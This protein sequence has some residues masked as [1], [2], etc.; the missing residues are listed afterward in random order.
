[1]ADEVGCNI[2]MKGDGHVGGRKVVCEHGCVPYQTIAKKD[3]HFTVLGFTNLLGVP[4]LCVI[5]ITVKEE[6]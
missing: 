2:C 6:D 4:I 1:M 3:K 5:I